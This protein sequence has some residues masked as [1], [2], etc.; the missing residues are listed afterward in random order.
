MSCTFAIGCT[1]Q[2][3][4]RCH[5]RVQPRGRSHAASLPGSLRS[6]TQPRLH[7][8]G[9]VRTLAIPTSTLSPTCQV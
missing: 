6:C 2:A 3:R 5:T 4:A 1:L 8:Q 9:A 7:I